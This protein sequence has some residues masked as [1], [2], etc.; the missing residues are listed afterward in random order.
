LIASGEASAATA[1]GSDDDDADD[2]SADADEIDEEFDR[3]VEEWFDSLSDLERSAMERKVETEYDAIVLAEAGLRRSELF[4]EVP[5]TR[6]PARSSSPRPD[7]AP[8]PSPRP[9][10]T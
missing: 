8:S 4:Y 10:R 3:T 6:L 9:T 2:E 5:T 7:R 1:E